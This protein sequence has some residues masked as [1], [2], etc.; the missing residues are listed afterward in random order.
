M[1]AR[2][3]KVTAARLNGLMEGSGYSV[4]EDTSL[5]VLCDRN[6]RE[7]ARSKKL[8]NLRPFIDPI[9]SEHNQMIAA[10]KNVDIRAIIKPTR[11]VKFTSLSTEDAPK[12]FHILAI[13]EWDRVV[14]KHW[15]VNEFMYEVIPMEYFVEWLVTGRLS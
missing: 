6:N 3:P 1:D 7:I 11:Q 5:Y 4:Y 14:V 9:I 8:R 10:G 15:K 13:V 2:T 12:T